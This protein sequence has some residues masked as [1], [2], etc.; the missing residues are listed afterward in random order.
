MKKK[1]ITSSQRRSEAYAK[2][3]SE[4][5]RKKEPARADLIQTEIFALALAGGEANKLTAAELIR[6][7]TSEARRDLRAAIQELDALMD[8]VFLQEMRE[9]RR[10]R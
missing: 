2:W 6:S 1:R 7:L 10:N 4:H 9:K 5:P 3:R 8:D